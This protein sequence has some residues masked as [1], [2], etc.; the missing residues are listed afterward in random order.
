ME[1]E[2]RDFDFTGAKIALICDKFVLTYLRDDKPTIPFPNLWDLPG[3]GKEG[4]ESPEQ[5]ATRE[6][7]E[8]F[9]LSVA[10][11]R[12]IWK[13][14]YEHATVVGEHAYFMVAYVT[15]EE[16]GSIRFGDEGQHWR[17]MTLKEFLK[18]SHA[19]PQLQT[20]LAHYLAE[21]GELDE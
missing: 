14:R 1:K 20:R 19:V 5:C 12:I 16:I 11:D 15:K 8:E 17:L 4:D 21:V 7:K 3:G 2:H 18:H 9:S 10:T 6:V 13:R